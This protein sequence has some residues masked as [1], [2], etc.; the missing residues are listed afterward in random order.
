MSSYLDE[1]YLTWLYSQV[2][3][4]KARPKSRTYWSLLRR[5]HETAFVWF[6]PN[7]DNRA[8]DGRDLRH[9]F[10]E[11]ERVS[12]PDQVD[13]YFLQEP[14][15][16]LEMLIALSRRLA[17][18]AEGGPRWW[19]W[20]LMMNIGLEP[21]NDSMRAIEEEVE[22]VLERV[23]FRTYDYDGTGG[24]FPLENAEDDQRKVELWYQLQNY[25][26]ED[27]YPR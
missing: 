8:E 5:M 19:F 7:D 1:A 26:I 12:L 6:I 11:Q 24:L 21:L 10:L 14:C 16:F 17:F 27:R 2:S 4:V 25:L 22:E 3:P 23:I 18:E 13:S 15:S 9:E 20:H